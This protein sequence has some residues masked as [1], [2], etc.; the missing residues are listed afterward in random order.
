MGALAMTSLLELGAV[1]ASRGDGLHTKLRE[2]LTGRDFP[3]SEIIH[4]DGMLQAGSPPASGNSEPLGDIISRLCH[5]RRVKQDLS[6]TWS[7]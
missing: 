7:A 6:R 3:N 1:A 2:L 4:H 5:F